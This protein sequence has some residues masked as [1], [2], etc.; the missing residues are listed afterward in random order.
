MRQA[1]ITIQG[2][3]VSLVLIAMIGSAMFLFLSQTAS[4]Y[5]VT[6]Q[7]ESSFTAYQDSYQNVSDEVQNLEEVLY[8]EDSSTLDVFSAFFKD[9]IQIV[10]TSVSSIPKLFKV[11]LVNAMEALNIPPQFHAYVLTLIVI[12][13]IFAFVAFLKGVNA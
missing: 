1:E 4:N 6:F 13:V 2:L 8:D 3:F 11:V 12:L 7:N 10:A 9:G 5:G